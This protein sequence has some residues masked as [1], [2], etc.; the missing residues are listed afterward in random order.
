MA[1]GRLE[2]AVA[3]SDEA[4]RVSPGSRE[5]AGA[6]RQAQAVASARSRGNALFKAGKLREACAAYEDGL[7]EHPG[8]AT[9]LCNRAACRCKLGE[10][11]AAL[12]ERP[13]YGKARLR[14]AACNDRLGRWEASVQDYEA[15]L[16]EAPGDEDVAGALAHART[17]LG[18]VTQRHAAV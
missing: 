11:E 10:W 12:G 8:N 1:M 2:A 3:A 6:A 4:V 16:R 7:R 13:S 5:A 14:R 9:L 15:L 18:G 17:Q